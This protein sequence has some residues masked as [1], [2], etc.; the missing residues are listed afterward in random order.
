M[1]MVLKIVIIIGLVT[2]SLIASQKMTIQELVALAS[3]YIKKPIVL[4]KNLDDKFYIYSQSSLNQNNINLILYEVLKNNGLRLAVYK[5][6]Y[7]L[8]QIKSEKLLNRVIKINYLND[9]SIVEIMK[10]TDVKYMYINNKIMFSSLNFK[11]DEIKNIIKS[12]DKPKK[13]KK[14]RITVLE[15]NVN[16]LKEFGAKFNLSDV[17][18]NVFNITLGNV[19]AVVSP[20]SIKQ[21]GMD[22]KALVQDGVTK[23]VT[24]PVLT[25][26]DRY[27]TKFDITRT[28]PV[29]TS[30]IAV[31]NVE[32][33]TVEN[34]EYKS[35]GIK[36][37]AE[38]ILLKG[39]T[40]LD[41]DLKLQDIISSANDKPE[42][43]D[44]MLKQK[45]LVPDNVVY[46]LSGFKKILKVTNDE[47]VPFLKDIPVLGYLFK[48][49]TK[50]DVEIMLQI[51]IEI[52]E[53]DSRAVKNFLPLPTNN[54]KVFSA[55]RHFDASQ[56]SPVEKSLLDTNE[57]TGV[58][59]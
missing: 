41:L 40:D 20:T 45:V 35:F 2:N 15:T 23:I 54:K 50:E 25:L 28:I 10:Y 55:G 14:M 27:P 21:F 9:K 51:L 34:I 31:E 53:D 12:F 13:Q 26:R 8:E 1:K 36:V 49:D 29:K 56:N 16:K 47:G 3:T 52:V 58:T 30:T 7:M 43:S 59:F 46:M 37:L 17:S 33:K 11:Y 39:Q 42:T 48:W 57:I 22:I 6:Y 4:D 5:E 32:T 24:N 44:K 19:N 38:P 18:S